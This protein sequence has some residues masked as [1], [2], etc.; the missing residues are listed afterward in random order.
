[1]GYFVD[2]EDS[3]HLFL[4]YSTAAFRLKKQLEDKKIKVNEEHRLFVYLPCGIG[5]APGG[6]TFGLKQLFGEHVH[7]IFVEPVQAPSVLPVLLT[8]EKEK[9]SVQD[10][11]N[12]DRREA[13]G[14]ADGRP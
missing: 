14:H 11:G 7:C 8:G 13:D 4:G 2:D 6:I 5:G 10:F 12:Y 1:K 9:V 3:D